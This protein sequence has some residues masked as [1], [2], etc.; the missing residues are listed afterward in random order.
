[1]NYYSDG[2]PGTPPFPSPPPDLTPPV[3][4]PISSPSVVVLE[5]AT[6][7][8]LRVKVESDVMAYILYCFYR[9]FSR[10]QQIYQVSISWSGVDNC[11]L[12]CATAKT[13]KDQ[14]PLAAQRFLDFYYDVSQDLVAVPLNEHVTSITLHQYHKATYQ[15]KKLHPKVMVKEIKE[16]NRLALYCSS[17]EV[18]SARRTFIS[19]VDSCSP[20]RL[21]TSYEGSSKNSDW[22]L[23]LTKKKPL[24]KRNSLEKQDSS[25]SESSLQDFYDCSPPTN[26]KGHSDITSNYRRQN[27]YKTTNSRQEFYARIQ[28]PSPRKESE[29]A[30]SSNGSSG[31]GSLGGTLSRHTGMYDATKYRTHSDSYYG[32]KHRLLPPLPRSDSLRHNEV[33]RQNQQLHHYAAA[34]ERH[35]LK[36]SPK[37]YATEPYVES[38]YDVTYTSSHIERPR[39]QGRLLSP[40]PTLDYLPQLETRYRPSSM[41]RPRFAIGDDVIEESLSLRPRTDTMRGVH[42][43][44]ISPNVRLRLTPDIASKPS[45]IPK[46]KSP[47]TFK[48]RHKNYFEVMT[49]TGIKI[50]VQEGDVTDVD[51]DV[52]VN[53]TNSHLHVTGE[54]A[55]AVAKHGAF[56]IPKLT[57]LHVSMK[58]LVPETKVV[59]TPGVGLPSV[60]I[61]HVVTPK[62]QSSNVKRSRKLLYNSYKNIFNKA[63]VELKARSIVLPV[64]GLCGGNKQSES[65]PLHI[66]TE[67]MY[68]ALVAFLKLGSPYLRHIRYMGNDPDQVNLIVTSIKPKIEN[69]QYDARFLR[70]QQTKVREL[71][72]SGSSGNIDVMSDVNT[73]YNNS[74]MQSLRTTPSSYTSSTTSLPY[75]NLHTLQRPHR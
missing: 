20:S 74:R 30:T 39:T 32:P 72:S 61:V 27:N 11:V 43:K 26:P 48:Q 33:F 58:G 29:D 3:I 70:Q 15:V 16:T 64:I 59:V 73:N 71:S 55:W 13:N 49:P 4:P 45:Y 38:D 40:S 75:G 18:E 57:K 41:S 8:L 54:L 5:T 17:S 35:V 7:G 52:M 22:E 50:E 6:E 68:Q 21:P 12:F 2:G 1:M 63:N 34:G 56:E 44:S 14:L 53:E 51:S 31:Y 47:F 60:H 10:I 67:M 62:W 36:R 23:P 69:V 9:E 19:A 28:G 24:E 46:L 65:Y 42:S 66:A 25:F 37:R